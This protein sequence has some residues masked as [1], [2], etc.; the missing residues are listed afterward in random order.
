MPFALE[1]L[2]VTRSFDE[3][4]DVPLMTYKNLMLDSYEFVWGIDR[5]QIASY[6]NETGN[7]LRIQPDLQQ[8]I[9]SGQVALLPPDN[10]LH[11]L[12][13]LQTHNRRVP[14]T[15]RQPF[16]EVF[17]F[18]T[19]EYRVIPLKRGVKLFA[20][21]P[22][23]SKVSALK[24]ARNCYH[25]A[26]SDAHPLF[27]LT[28]AS[29][30]LI[31]PPKMVKINLGDSLIRCFNPWFMDAPLDFF[32]DAYPG[33]FGRPM[34]FK[35]R[36][37]KRQVPPLPEV[38][39]TSSSSTSSSSLSF[40]DSEPSPKRPRLST[41]PS[42]NGKNICK[43]VADCATADFQSCVGN[44]KDIGSYALEAARPLQVMLPVETRP[45]LSVTKPRNTKR[46]RE[47]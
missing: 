34:P 24:A 40:D 5:G 21:N 1:H 47:E 4:V 30:P 44:D 2:N 18:E 38:A 6:F 14:V 31:D 32:K 39:C 19:C 15:Q 8:A 9:E 27:V 45:V 42:S 43:W 25:L 35:Y 36:H 23:T 16:T 26:T 10:I 29:R 11:R 20:F 7:F 3:P 33:Q 28:H 17:P 37:L 12:Y 41:P 22:E 46:T 13:T